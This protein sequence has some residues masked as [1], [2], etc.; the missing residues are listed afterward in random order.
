M[1]LRIAGEL[2]VPNSSLCC[3]SPPIISSCDCFEEENGPASSHLLDFELVSNLSKY[4][5][6]SHCHNFPNSDSSWNCCCPKPVELLQKIPERERQASIRPKPQPRHKEG[7]LWPPWSLKLRRVHAAPRMVRQDLIQS[8][9]GCCLGCSR[10]A[11]LLWSLGGPC[12]PPAL[13]TQNFL[14]DRPHKL[15]LVVLLVLVQFCTFLTL[16]LLNSVSV[17]QPTSNPRIAQK[18]SRKNQFKNNS[19]FST[20]PT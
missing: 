14:W 5:L 13:I 10:Q 20:S 8:L 12:I 3:S 9:Y 15:T 7:N 16:P 2:H 19:K 4:A 1:F 18:S 6:C 17:N 11:C